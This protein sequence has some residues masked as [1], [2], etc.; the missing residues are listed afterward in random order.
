MKYL[1]SGIIGFFLTL[2]V[3]L[4]FQDVIKVKEARAFAAQIRS[5][6]D[7]SSDMSINVRPI[8]RTSTEK[9]DE[10]KIKYYPQYPTNAAR[11][12]I[13]G[14]VTL[15]FKVSKD[16]SVQNVKVTDSNPP[17]VFDDAAVEAVSKWEFA[18]NDLR[19]TPQKLRLNFSLQNAVG[20]D[21][22]PRAE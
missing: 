16:G 11:D 2:F 20:I 19:K 7:R 14:Y 1:I 17:Q 13:E 18:Q 4:P 9:R 6:L 10:P 3:S 12:K 5:K 15:S 8:A 21:Q 22:H